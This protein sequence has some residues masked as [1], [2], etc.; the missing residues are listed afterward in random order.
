MKTLL[1]ILGFLLL[2]L[3][4][5]VGLFTFIPG[6]KADLVYQYPQVPSDAESLEG[7]ITEKENKVAN[8]KLGNRAFI[9]W[10][11][12][13]KSVTPYSLVYLHGFSASHEEGGTVHDR[14]AETFGMN[15]YYSR[16]ANHG[17]EGRDGMTTLQAESYF[18]SAMEAVAIGKKLGE[19]VIIAGT[20][21][22]ATLG[23]PIMAHDDDIFAGIFYS[24]NIALF[25]ESTKLLPKPF[26]LNLAR[27]INDGPYYKFDPPKGAEQFWTNEYKLEAVRELQELINETMV[28]E[29]FEKIEQPVLFCSFYESEEVQDEVVSVQAMRTCMEQLSTPDHLKLFKELPETQAHAMCSGFYS[30]DT[31]GPYTES[32]K[33][34]KAIMN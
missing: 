12:S 24:P 30:K 3:I 28:E 22:G 33:F 29:T 14:L 25:N 7:F 4:L 20:S 16:L 8:I 23:L 19:K 13:T 15:T 10:A 26:G 27:V 34:L 2:V 1:K 17:L 32:V 21:T 6:G 18:A 9:H 11:D 5:L 31:I